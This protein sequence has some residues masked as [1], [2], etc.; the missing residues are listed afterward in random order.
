MPDDEDTV[1]AVARRWAGRA[2]V[3]VDHTPKADMTMVSPPHTV[4]VARACRER[5]G[6]EVMVDP[7]LVGY[8]MQVRMLAGSD[9][10][11]ADAVEQTMVAEGER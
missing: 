2:V 9:I 4:T 10:E 6:H 7:I 11:T 8:S 1:A 5:E 3:E